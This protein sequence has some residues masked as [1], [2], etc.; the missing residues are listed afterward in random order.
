MFSIKNDY[1]LNEGLRNQWA[2]SIQFASQ[3]SIGQDG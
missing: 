3:I 2:P 1:A